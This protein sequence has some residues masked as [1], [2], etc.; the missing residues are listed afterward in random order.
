MNEVALDKWKPPASHSRYYRMTMN[1]DGIPPIEVSALIPSFEGVNLSSVHIERIGGPSEADKKFR[2]QLYYVVGAAVV[3]S[4]HIE[5]AMQRLVI[6]TTGGKKADCSVV[7]WD[8][9]KLHDELRKQSS[10]NGPPNNTVTAALDWAE[11]HAIK[12]IRDKFVH[13]SWWDYAG[14]G[15][16][17]TR[18]ERKTSGSTMVGTLE[19]LTAQANLLHAYAVKLDDL[20]GAHW[21][22]F[23]LPAD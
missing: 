5:A 1:F 16:V 13:A 9:T 17:C 10:K 21:V 2:M 6:L 18:I 8:W 3:A 19:E 14:V 12:K 11:K 7:N 4:G 23:Y 15:V 20:V 22:N